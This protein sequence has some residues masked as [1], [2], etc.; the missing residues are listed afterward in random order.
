MAELRSKGVNYGQHFIEI[1]LDEPVTIQ[2]GEDGAKKFNEAVEREGLRVAP[3]ICGRQ[4]LTD[5]LICG[6]EQGHS[7][8]GPQGGHGSF[9]R[10]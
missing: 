4:R 6:R 3:E 2:P 9:I 1:V 7:D 10:L 5:G 8:D